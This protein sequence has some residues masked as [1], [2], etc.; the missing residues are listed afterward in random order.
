MLIFIILTLKALS[1][2]NLFSS[3]NSISRIIF[4]LWDP[5]GWSYK[6]SS[7]SLFWLFAWRALSLSQKN[8]R[9]ISCSRVF[10]NYLKFPD[11]WKKMVSF[12]LQ[13]MANFLNA[14]E[15]EIKFSQRCPEWGSKTIGKESWCKFGYIE[16]IFDTMHAALVH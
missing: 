15:A 11:F 13:R 12:L 10:H 16:Y 7:F 3:L 6:L 14:C 1:T 9:K 4:H 8:F 5:Q 2:T